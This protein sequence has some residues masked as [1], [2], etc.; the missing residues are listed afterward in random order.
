MISI[1]M[2]HY[3]RPLLYGCTFK[4]SLCS[5]HCQYI[6]QCNIDQLGKLWW[7]PRT[8]SLMYNSSNMYN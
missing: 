7:L 2:I 5:D 1:K 4:P 6:V 8:A 3:P